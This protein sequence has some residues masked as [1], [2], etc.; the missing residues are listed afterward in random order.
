MAATI[1]F[2]LSET[3]TSSFDFPPGA[4]AAR[5]LEAEARIAQSSGEPM[6]RLVWEV[7]HPDYGT[8]KLFDNVPSKNQWKA[9]NFYAAWV[10][11]ENPNDLVAQGQREGEVDPAALVGTEFIVHIGTRVADRGKYMGQE[12]R[13]TV[14]PFYSPISRTDLLGY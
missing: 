14:P 8:A 3:P 11:A 1:V 4:Y 13:E 9:T 5:V 2:Q 7:Y 10:G 6:L 12:V